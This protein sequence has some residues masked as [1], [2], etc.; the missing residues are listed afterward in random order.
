LIESLIIIPHTTSG[1]FAKKSKDYR[2]KLS[3]NN[4]TQKQ[5]KTKETKQL[6]KK[7]GQYKKC[8]CQKYFI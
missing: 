5:L 8:L 4:L 1:N 7:S 2:E 6:L 3:D